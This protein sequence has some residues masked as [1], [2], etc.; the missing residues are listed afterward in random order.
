[1]KETIDQKSL[2]DYK[3]SRYGNFLKKFGN[4]CYRRSASNHHEN[5]IRNWHLTTMKTAQ[6][7]G[8]KLL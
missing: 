5:P 1:M 6:K 2:K 8:T 4:H 7:I 3:G